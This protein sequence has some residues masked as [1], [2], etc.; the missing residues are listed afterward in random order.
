MK[1][2]ICDDSIKDL[3]NIGRLLEKYREQ[4]PG[5]EFE[6]ET[7][8][9]PGKLK[10]KILQKD[11]ADIYILDILMSETTG[12]DLGSQIRKHAGKNVIIYIT[13]TEDFALDAFE[14][15]AARYLLKPVDQ[16][17]FFEALE[18]GF[19]QIKEENSPL[20]VV[21]TK[22]GLVAV[23]YVKIEYIE[24]ASRMLEVHLTNGEQLKS[25]FIRKSFE[26]ELGALSSDPSFLQV[27]KSFLVN[28]NHVKRLEG[29]HVVMDSGAAVPVSKK[30]TTTVKR[31]YLMFVSEQYNK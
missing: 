31:K 20:Y 24:N 30:N 23:P 28:M 5:T 25:I 13:S 17:K 2:A 10:A 4:R 9:D 12:I 6:V 29:N 16:G 22:G 27:H 1:I 8:T 7:Y 18:Y 3:M 19:S 26:E 14:V 11:L 21:K 15:H